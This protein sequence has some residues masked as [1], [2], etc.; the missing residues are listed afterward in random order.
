MH[1]NTKT[2][3]IKFKTSDIFFIEKRKWAGI[4]RPEPVLHITHSTCFYRT[5]VST[6]KKTSRNSEREEM[7]WWNTGC[8]F[9]EIRYLLCSIYSIFRIFSLIFRFDETT[10]SA[11]VCRNRG[12][13]IGGFSR[14]YAKISSTLID[15]PN[16]IVLNAGD[17]FT[18][19][20]WYL[21][22]KWNVTQQFMNKIKFD[23]VVSNTTDL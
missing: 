18:G 5:P 21:V 14:L 1:K 6:L 8:C 11:G 15:K 3:W 17:D 4:N 9:I 10:D 7:N 13:C 16:T 19:T 20:R 12:K 22:G 2:E 23:A